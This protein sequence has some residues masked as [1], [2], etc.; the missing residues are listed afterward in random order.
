MVSVTLFT[1]LYKKIYP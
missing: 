1:P